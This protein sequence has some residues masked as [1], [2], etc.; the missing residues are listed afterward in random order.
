[1]KYI[2]IVFP[3]SNCWWKFSFASTIIKCIKIEKLHLIIFHN[4]TFYKKNVFHL[5]DKKLGLRHFQKHEKNLSNLELLNS[6]FQVNKL[7]SLKHLNV[8]IV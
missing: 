4:I 8:Y 7:T 2:K 1:M 6:S 3:P 5:F